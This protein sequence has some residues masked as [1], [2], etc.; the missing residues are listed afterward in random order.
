M[1]VVRRQGRVVAQAQTSSADV[2]ALL[3][4]VAVPVAKSRQFTPSMHVLFLPKTLYGDVWVA[5][6]GKNDQPLVTAINNDIQT[7][8]K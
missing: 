6:A 1:M 2:G 5:P 4:R 8:M 3:A 7:W